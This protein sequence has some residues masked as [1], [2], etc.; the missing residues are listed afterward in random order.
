MTNDS[1][2]ASLLVL[3]LVAGLGV[4]CPL[5]V[6]SR[7]PLVD[8]DEGLHASIARRWSRAAIG[9]CRTN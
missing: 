8:P 5:L 7:I 6:A 2:K 1:W 4:V 9:S 3:A